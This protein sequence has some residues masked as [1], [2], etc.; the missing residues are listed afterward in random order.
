M[1]QAPDVPV[2]KGMTVT[3]GSRV[4]PPTVVHAALPSDAWRIS[5]GEDA[6]D[7]GR[8]IVPRADGEVRFHSSE[9]KCKTDFCSKFGEALRQH[10]FGT[11][12]LGNLEISGTRWTAKDL[13]LLLLALVDAGATTRRFKAFK[14]GLDDDSLE[15]IVEWLGRTKHADLPLEIHLSHNSISTIGFESLVGVLRRRKKK[16]Y[17]GGAFRFGFESI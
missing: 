4:V 10:P 14:C 7:S 8:I 13:R 11:C 5:P 17:V 6:T 15:V 16:L 12:R 1:V 3:P 9:W 2:P